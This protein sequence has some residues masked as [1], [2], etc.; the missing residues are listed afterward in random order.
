MPKKIIGAELRHL[1]NLMSRQFERFNEGI[2]C[3][4]L[5]GP[6]M[7]ILKFLQ[8]NGERDV[9]QRDVEKAMSI[10]KSTCSKVLSTMEGKGLIR[11]EAVADARFKKICLTELG[12]N[13]VGMTD[14]II[15]TM[16]A[17]LSEGISEQELEIFLSCVERMKKN[18]M[19]Q[20]ER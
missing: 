17:R 19:R 7:F 4:P 15:E 2:G 20:L 3:G 12:R 14:R 13:V 18:V 16:E 1:Q 10:T 9:Y 6:N 5:S 8:Q 11:R